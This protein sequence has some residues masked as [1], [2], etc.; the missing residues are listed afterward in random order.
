MPAVG[1]GEMREFVQQGVLRRR[2]VGHEQTPLVGK[3]CGFEG[4]SQSRHPKVR[5]VEVFGTAQFLEP[6]ARFGQGEFARG[7]RRFEG[8]FDFVRQC[9]FGG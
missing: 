1:A 7:H 5:R 8:R 4:W 2:H 6:G 9:G 3:R